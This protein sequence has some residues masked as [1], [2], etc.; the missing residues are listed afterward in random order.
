MEGSLVSALVNTGGLGV[1]VLILYWL[2]RDAIKAFREE[3]ATERSSHVALMESQRQTNA[4]QMEAERTAWQGQNE[5][6]VG[7]IERLSE[8]VQPP[9]P[10]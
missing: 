9:R 3:M 1:A 8:R 6:I 10:E 5:K 4:A 2:H 7:A